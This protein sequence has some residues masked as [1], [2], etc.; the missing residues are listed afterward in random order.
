[1]TTTF[2]GCVTFEPRPDDL[3]RAVTQVAAL[4]GGA[5]FDNSTTDA[6]RTAVRKACAAADLTYLGDGR[7]HGTGAAMNALVQQAGSAEW[8]LYLDQDST[9]VRG[10]D[11]PLDVEEA[12]AA[13]GSFLL[14]SDDDTAQG[15]SRWHAAKY[16]LAS[17]TSYRISAVQRLGGFDELMF[18]D[19][20]DHDLC[21]N[22][23]RNG[24][25]LLR[26]NHRILRHE[27]GTDSRHIAN[28]FRL[29]RH[30]S[31]R[32][33]LMWRNSTVLVLR[34]GRVF[35]A[36]LLKHLVVRVTETLLGA[37]AYRDV[38][39]LSGAVTGVLAGL[40]NRPVLPPT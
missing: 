4:G 9:V 22:A 28:G 15:M 26:D 13:V 38:R 12:V 11:R 17:G 8:L 1:M 33:R 32:R 19:T 5:V 31:W 27:I 34:Y 40:R 36:E 10:F 29:A 2:V 6:A 30:P 18:L 25:T 7:N 20:V 21:L 16:L 14:H 35:P 37:I 23:R 39:Y 3:D 24:M